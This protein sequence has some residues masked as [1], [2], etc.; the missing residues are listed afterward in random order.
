[1]TP[2]ESEY[3]IAN[4]IAPVGAGMLSQSISQGEYSKLFERN[5]F[6]VVSTTE[7]LSRGAWYENGAQFGIF[8][9]TAYSL[10]GIYRRDPGQRGNNDF[11]ERDTRVQIKQQLTYQDSIF[12]RAGW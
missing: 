11:E 9:N 8:G 10:E 4:L 3:L 12:V 1:E 7:Y 5:R 2:S 6:G